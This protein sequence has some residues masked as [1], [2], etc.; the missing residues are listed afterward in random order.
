[1]KKSLVLAMA[2]ALGVTASAY[3]ANPFSDVPAG[4]W[5]YDSLAKL[6]DTGVI[7]GYPDGTFKGD[8]T[9]TRYEAAQITARA[10]AKG[11]DCDK[12][13]AEFSSELEALGVKVA[14]L[15]KN[16]DNFKLAGELRYHYMSKSKDAE[17]ENDLRARI[18]FH[19]QINEDWSFTGLL[20][21]NKGLQNNAGEEDVYLQRSYVEGRLGGLK[22]TAG[23]YNPFIAD[24]LVYDTRANGIEAVYGEDTNIC[25]MYGKMADGLTLAEDMNG[26]NYF[27][28]QAQTP[29]AKGLTLKAGY[30]NA[31]D[32]SITTSDSVVKNN[33]VETDTKTVGKMNMAIWNVGLVY[34]AENFSVAGTYLKGNT[35]KGETNFD[36]DAL[37]G[38]NTGYAFGVT[39]K[40]AE[41]SEPGSWGAFANYWNQGAGTYIAHTTDANVFDGAGFKGWGVGANYAVAKNIV[42]TLA[43]YDTEGKN[44]EG[45]DRRVW[46]D[47]TFTF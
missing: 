2:M 34:E 12:L 16:T 35:E 8:E 42:T 4:H 33:L 18:E 3:A 22:V 11:A 31:R 20:E 36:T 21:G 44:N 15:E 26:A 47:V 5:A 13:A 27:A 14:G 41:A 45:H 25:L 30:I 32:F 43:Y 40:G 46:A 28:A 1:M 19:G 23:R 17:H 10:M 37:D 7:D 29:I 6:A 24:G 38:A 9:I 39:Y